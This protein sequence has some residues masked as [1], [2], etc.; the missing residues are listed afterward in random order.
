MRVLSNHIEIEKV[1]NPKKIT[2]TKLASILGYNEYTTPFQTWCDITHVYSPDFEDNKYTIAGKIIEPI[3]AEY[4]KNNF[5]EEIIVSPTDRFGE[6]YFE[7][8]HGNFYDDKIFGGMWDF[9]VEDSDGDVTYVL[10]MKTTSAKNKRKWQ[11]EGPPFHYVL[12]AALY[13]WL[14]N[15]DDFYIIAGFL[16]SAD[17]AWP[18]LFKPNKDNTMLWHI[19]VSQ[20]CSDFESVII[21]PCIEWYNKY[22]ITGISPE[23]DIVKDAEYLEVINNMEMNTEISNEGNFL[24]TKERVDNQVS[25]AI[26][27]SEDVVRSYTKE[28]DSIMLNVKTYVVDIE[29]PSLDILEKY[30][31]ELAN[32]VYFM[33]EKVEKVGLHDDIS[34]LVMNEA[35]NKA[36]LDYKNSNNGVP[37]AKKPTDAE[38]T[39]VA[40]TKIIEEST[41]NSIYNRTYKTIK[42]KIDSA[43]TMISTIS[44]IISLRSQEMQLTQIQPNVPVTR[45]ILNESEV[46]F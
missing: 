22:V 3:L 23:F 8:T 44:K 35:Y 39:T 42:A 37:G 2:G 18:D 31:L 12:Q 30:F 45:Q 32:C 27:L 43:Q 21:K 25:M 14:L 11:N 1:S 13:S 9:L 10:E 5:P 15:I 38:S 26:S 20:L 34:K 7:T 46:R 16:D 29:N 4:V 40:E 33:S 19:K 41:I 28:L 24:T 36:Y 17:Y 6:N